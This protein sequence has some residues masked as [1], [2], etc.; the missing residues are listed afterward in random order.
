MRQGR[1]DEV[2]AMADRKTILAIVDSSIDQKQ[3]L[4]QHWEGSFN[5]Y[6]ELVSQVPATARNAFQRIYAMIQHFGAR[7]YAWMREERIRYRFFDDPFENGADAIFGLAKPGL[8]PVVT[9]GEPGDGEVYDER[10][11]SSV[12]Q[13]IQSAYPIRRKLAG[14]CKKHFIRSTDYAG[15]Q[16]ER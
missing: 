12:T 4:S 14:Y 3:F 10:Y 7:R 8:T 16:K 1:W 6:L 5:D 13:A 2:N 11:N 9:E 15:S